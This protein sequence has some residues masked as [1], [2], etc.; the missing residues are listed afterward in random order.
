MCIRHTRMT[1]SIHTPQMKALLAWLK[2]ARLD[3]GLTMVQLG[4]ALGKPHS[5]VQKVE[6]GERRLD[7]VEFAWY[8]KALNLDPLEG[9][10]VV[11]TFEGCSIEQRHD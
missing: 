11:L 6:L 8:C 2:Q 4:K 10:K 9:M 7:L 3:H 5:F 1:V